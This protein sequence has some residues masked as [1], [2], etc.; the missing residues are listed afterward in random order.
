MEA[1]LAEAQAELDRSQRRWSRGQEEWL[2]EVRVVCLGV[3]VGD[4]VLGFVGSGG[5][6]C[7][8][9]C[10][11]GLGCPGRGEEVLAADCGIADGWGLG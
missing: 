11:V 10:F 5:A 8:V 3:V 9:A 1:R 4:P 2:A 7:G 6:L